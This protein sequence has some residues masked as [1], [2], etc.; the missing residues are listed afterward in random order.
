MFYG[1]AINQVLLSPEKCECAEANRG[2][3]KLFCAAEYDYGERRCSSLFL[4]EFAEV[5]L[6]KI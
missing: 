3:P 2:S 1:S 4:R 6:S 5:T